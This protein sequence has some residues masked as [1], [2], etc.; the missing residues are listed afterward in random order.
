MKLLKMTVTVYYDCRPEFD[1]EAYEDEPLADGRVYRNRDERIEKKCAEIGKPWV[2]YD[3]N[4]HKPFWRSLMII[5]DTND[6]K[7][8]TDAAKRLYEEA[9]RIIKW[10][11][12][13]FIKN[14]EGL[15][16]PSN[17]EIASIVSDALSGGNG[18]RMIGLAD[19]KGCIMTAAMEM[20]SHFVGE[21]NTLGYVSFFKNAINDEI[22]S[23]LIKGLPFKLKGD[24]VQFE[25]ENAMNSAIEAVAR[26][27]SG[28]SAM[29]YLEIK[30]K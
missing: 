11:S 16:P 8:R 14:V 7:A 30:K 18:R 6:E 23:M 2:E 15:V 22:L 5:E 3:G 12:V 29:R 4:G 1:C 9:I 27:L 26:K 17:E 24:Y 13:S 21:E 20:G 28:D 10:D 19:F 25:N